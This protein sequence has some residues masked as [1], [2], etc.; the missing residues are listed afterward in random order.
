[1][2]QI[3]P[4]ETPAMEPIR[5]ALVQGS[6]WFSGISEDTYLLFI[7]YTLGVGKMVQLIK[8]LASM[9]T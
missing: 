6:G 7:K 8:F 2:T 4:K 1:M 5:I 9:R 3:P